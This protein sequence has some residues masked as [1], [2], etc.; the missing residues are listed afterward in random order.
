MNG[1]IYQIIY[2]PVSNKE[3]GFFYRVVVQLV[4]TLHL[5]CRGRTFESCL[6][7]REPSER[8]PLQAWLSKSSFKCTGSSVGRAGE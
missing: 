8:V 7:D 6:L 2:D 3:I 4:R 1:N 5:G